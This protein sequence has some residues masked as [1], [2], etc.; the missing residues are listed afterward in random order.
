MT[1]DTQ[2]WD[3]ISVFVSHEPVFVAVFM[4]RFCFFG[5]ISVITDFSPR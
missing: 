5:L 4:L 1:E 2:F 3:P